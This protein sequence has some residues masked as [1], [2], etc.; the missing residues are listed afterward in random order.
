MIRSVLTVLKGNVAAQLIGIAV[1]PILSRYFAPAAFGNF[2]AFQAIL[3]FLLV[4]VTLR[5]EIAI[6]RTKDDRDTASVMA[7]CGLSLLGTTLLC[8]LVIGG[9]VYIGQPAILADL[10]F[11][12]WLIPLAMGLGGAGQLLGYVL[13]KR[14]RFDQSSNSKIVQ[15][16]ANA[17]ASVGLAIGAPSGSGVIVGDIA[18]RLALVLFLA[19]HTI[20]EIRSA[21][22]VGWRDI[23]QAAHRYRD[24][25]LVSLPTTLVNI[26]GLSI[27]PMFVYS[28]FGADVAGQFS[29][30]ERTAGLPVAMIVAAVSQ[31]HM[32]YLAS[33]MREG[34]DSAR[35]NFRRIS[36]Y[37]ALLAI[38]PAIV[39]TI[40]AVPIFQFVLGPGWEESARV[41]QIMAPSYFLGLVTGGVN[42][43]LTVVGRQAE[44]LLWAGAR[45]VAMCGLWILAPRAGWGIEAVV[46][47]YSAILCLFSI[48]MAMM[49]YRALPKAQER[50]HE[51]V[52]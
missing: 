33:D 41:A 27:T 42:M 43:T 22:S 45:L 24:L 3:T 52:S 31:V 48:L 6:L 44:Q 49:A 17:G 19:K 14:H 36:L 9:A 34:G 40:F 51:V 10:Q 32:A 12:W 28:Q 25:S 30:A 5:F 2:Y 29:M 38:V 11:P 50:H 47:G 26:G 46:M 18:G 15:S 20:A 13:I 37:L 8:S 1:L 16:V 4:L 35:K 7:I 23:R 21:F 39:G